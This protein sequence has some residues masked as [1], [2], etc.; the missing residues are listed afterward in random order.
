MKNK[1]KKP[2]PFF[3]PEKRPSIHHVYHAAHHTF[4]TKNTVSAT[5]FLKNP[6]KNRTFQPATTPKKTAQKVRP[7]HRT[8]T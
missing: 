2:V 3:C 5:K 8:P 7:N 1:V 6:S 4:T